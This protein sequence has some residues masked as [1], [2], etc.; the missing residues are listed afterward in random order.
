MSEFDPAILVGEHLHAQFRI[1]VGQPSTILLDHGLVSYPA[2]VL[3]EF[4]FS[5]EEITAQVWLP[6]DN[7]PPGGQY[8]GCLLATLVQAAQDVQTLVFLEKLDRPVPAVHAVIN[9][10][11]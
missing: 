5:V 6:I 11:V 1:A 9:Q 2:Q 3:P 10:R 8:F 4:L 7:S